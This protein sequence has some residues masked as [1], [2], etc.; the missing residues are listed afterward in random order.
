[1]LVFLLCTHLSVINVP[2]D[3]CL[4]MSVSIPVAFKQ[5]RERMFYS[6]HVQE[7]LIYPTV[8]PE[9]GSCNSRIK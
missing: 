5:F 2:R 6:V 1:M 7:L 8:K 9:S 4:A 3:T